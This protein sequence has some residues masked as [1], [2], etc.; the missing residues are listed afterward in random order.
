[1]PAAMRT[2]LPEQLHVASNARDPSAIVSSVQQPLHLV[3]ALASKFLYEAT[4]VSI[5]I[6]VQCQSS[7]HLCVSFDLVDEARC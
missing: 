3:E 5:V 2:G 4:Y 6:S 1:M 7:A